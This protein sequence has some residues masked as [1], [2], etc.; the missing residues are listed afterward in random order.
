MPSAQVIDLS[1][2]PRAPT[3][4]ERMTESFS[5]RFLEN[6]RDKQDTDALSD[7]YKKYK[8]EGQSIDDAIMAIQTRSDMS[9]TARVNAASQ[10]LNLKKTNTQLLRDQQRIDREQAKE[11]AKIDKEKTKAALEADLDQKELDFLE[12]TSGKSLKPTE[13]YVQ[14]RQQGIPRVRANQLATLHRL[15]GK[16]DRLTEND[17]AKQY[18]FELKE[19]DRKI[20]DEVSSKKKKA[21]EEEREKIKEMRKRDLQ[22][23]RK[24]ERD[25]EPEL[26]AVEKAQVAE[27]EAKEEEKAAAE[28][29]KEEQKDY[30]QAFEEMLTKSFPPSK[31]PVGTDKWVLAEKSPDGKKRH[32]KSDGKKWVL[33]K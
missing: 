3:T 24:G 14:A 13:L 12:Q 31:V 10:L 18:D 8:D 16:E 15:E 17:I 4:L 32:Y 30:D 7:I 23:Y 2:T 25:F 22:R 19:L 29:Q 1:P 5:S 21:I 26:H 6:K 27:Q 20:R 9:P 28:N 33:V 11:D